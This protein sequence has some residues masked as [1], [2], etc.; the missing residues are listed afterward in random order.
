M[1]DKHK[2]KVATAYL[3]TALWAETDDDGEPLDAKYDLP[4]CLPET[5]EKA[6]NAVES[7]LAQPGVCEA[8]MR[9]DEFPAGY[10]LDSLG[11]DLWLT[12]NHHGTGFWDRG[13]PDPVGAVL[14]DAAHALGGCDAYITDDGRV[15][16]G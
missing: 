15:A 16:I 5:W 3:R 1:N 14:T 4:D 11:Q 2:R 9:A 10:D 12:R 6:G 8:L 13:L 7:F